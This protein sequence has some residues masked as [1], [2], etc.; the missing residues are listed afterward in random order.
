MP[1]G[2]LIVV[3]EKLQ[4]QTQLNVNPKVVGWP[5]VVNRSSGNN[6]VGKRLINALG[7]QFFIIAKPPDKSEAR[8]C[9]EGFINL[10]LLINFLRW[11]LR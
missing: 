6:T 2:L 10:F 1:K 3:T 4:L 8:G 5:S 11:P 7:T 9:D